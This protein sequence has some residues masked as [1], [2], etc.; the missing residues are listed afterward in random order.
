MK[1]N[2][3]LFVSFLLIF[4]L[5]GINAGI[6]A[7]P[8]CNEDFKKELLDKRANTLGGQELLE[9][10]KNQ[11]SSEQNV[12]RPV[13]YTIDPK[14]NEVKETVMSMEPSSDADSLG[15]IAHIKIFISTW[16]FV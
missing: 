6:E 13:S 7:C 16:F 8:K 9:A 5:L 3:I 15:V 14:T 10:I 12:N 11:S 1:K 2:K 4:L